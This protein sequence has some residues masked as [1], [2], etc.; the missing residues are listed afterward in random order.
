MEEYRLVYIVEAWALQSADEGLVVKL[1]SNLQ[2]QVGL[3]RSWLCF[4][5]EEEEGRRKKEE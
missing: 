3:S 2:T 1:H 4:L 5:M